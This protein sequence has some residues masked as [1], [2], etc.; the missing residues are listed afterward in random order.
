MGLKNIV[1]KNS[2]SLESL[3]HPKIEFVLNLKALVQYGYKEKSGKISYSID[4]NLDGASVLK[5]ILVGEHNVL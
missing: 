3:D 1:I 4:S 2:G 5:I